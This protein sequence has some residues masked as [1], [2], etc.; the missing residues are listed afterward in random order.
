ML[1]KPYRLRK[2][3]QFKRAIEKGQKLT[4]R[5]FIVYLIE[6]TLENASNCQYGIAIPKS[7]V[8]G[9]VKRKKC[10]KQIRNILIRILKNHRDSCQINENHTHHKIVII[11]RPPYLESDFR[12]NQRSLYG[13]LFFTFQKQADNLLGE[14]KNT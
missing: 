3:R 2:D 7:L 14:R 12:A 9:A 6:P 1:W 5:N 10:I 8:E 13:L 4:N 11:I